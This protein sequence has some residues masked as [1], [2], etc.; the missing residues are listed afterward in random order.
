MT[1]RTAEREA[2]QRFILESARVLFREK[3]IEATRMDDIAGAAEYTRRTLYAY[4][5]SR[6]DICLRIHLEDMAQRWERQ[7]EALAGVEGAW[8]RILTWAD[9]LYRHWKENP[10]SMRMEQYWDFHG[11]ERNR[12]SDEVF[13]R[14]EALNGKLAEALR[15]IFREGVEDGSFRPDL[16]VDACISQFLYSVRAVLGRALSS[17]YSF[18]DF[19]PDRYVNHYLDL[20][21]RGIL[22]PNRGTEP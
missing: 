20:Y 11:I 2:R 15:E 14:F 17:S 22:N 5:R 8:P 10:H 3:G 19:E 12:I 16:S 13:D 6:D 9:T 4:F 7:K 21:G 18:A 1:R